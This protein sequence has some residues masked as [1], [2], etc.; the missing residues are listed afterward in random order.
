MVY[1][2]NSNLNQASSTPASQG[3]S[4]RKSDS[5]RGLDAD[6]DEYKRV[7]PAESSEGG[8]SGRE[9]FYRHSMTLEQIRQLYKST[10]NFMHKTDSVEGKGAAVAAMDRVQSP[11]SSRYDTSQSGQ[12]SQSQELVSCLKQSL[13]GVGKEQTVTSLSSTSTHSNGASTEASNTASSSHSA[14]DSGYRSQRQT[15]AGRE[16]PNGQALRRR[17]KKVLL[18][19]RDSAGQSTMGAITFQPVVGP[20]VRPLFPDTGIDPSI[21]APFTPAE[22]RQLVPSS[23]EGQKAFTEA[24]SLLERLWLE[25]SRLSFTQTRISSRE[26]ALA[27][28]LLLPHTTADRCMERG[29]KAETLYRETQAAP[30]KAITVGMSGRAGLRLSVG[31]FYNWLMDAG[32]VGRVVEECTA[33]YLT[34]VVETFLCHWD[35]PEARRNGTIGA[36]VSLDSV[37]TLEGLLRDSHQKLIA[38]GRLPKREVEF[39][40][41]A[42]LTLYYFLQRHSSRVSEAQVEEWLEKVLLYTGHRA[43]GQQSESRVGMSDVYQAA[44]LVLWP[45]FDCPP[46]MALPE[47]WVEANRL[48]W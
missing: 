33:V 46:S 6:E 39:E 9:H 12:S 25:A 30:R 45:N 24:R 23:K 1:Y 36:V 28:K 37:S 18:G 2:S 48:L 44:R 11:L 38:E 29:E 31:R 3:D 27:V 14:G 41:E 13:G 26:I 21:S 42:L 16:P 47:G 43:A 4:P 40:S 32:A 15:P 5:D 17:P 35:Q 22:V 19:E 20:Q 10:P 8:G 7:S 34:A